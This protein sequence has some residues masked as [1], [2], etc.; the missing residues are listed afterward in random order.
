MR[1]YRKIDWLIVQ[2]REAWHTVNEPGR[3]V[4][5]Q[6][7]ETKSEQS[8]KVCVFS[9]SSH[10]WRIR[11]ESRIASVGGGNVFFLRET[12]RRRLFQLVD[13][14][15][16]ISRKNLILNWINL[17][18]NFWGRINYCALI[19]EFII[20]STGFVNWRETVV[21]YSNIL[22]FSFRFRRFF[23]NLNEWIF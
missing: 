5:S 4:R 6:N 1:E 17:D 10:S 13:G 8:F 14:N 11:R 2:P 19:I 3:L 21:I 15:C 9:I 22:H 12:N 18:S 20:L 7:R 23:A 16:F